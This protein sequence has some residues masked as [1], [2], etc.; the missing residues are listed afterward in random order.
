MRQHNLSFEFLSRKTTVVPCSTDMSISVH[1]RG[2]ATIIETDV[3]LQ[4]EF[5]NARESRRGY[6]TLYE[7]R[8]LVCEHRAPD[9]VT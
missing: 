6:T 5:N 1:F 4:R 7:S 2:A 3:R 9:N 8:Y